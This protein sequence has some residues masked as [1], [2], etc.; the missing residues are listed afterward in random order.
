[1]PAK[2]RAKAS[3]AKTVVIGGGNMGG[4]I[5]RGMV[6]AGV[7]AAAEVV[8]VDVD[9]ARREALRVELEVGVAAEAGAD[10]LAG[11]G[12]VL[13]AVKPQVVEG[14]LAS[15]RSALRGE[16]LVVS[17]VAGV[18]T[19]AVH[20]ALGGACRVVRA[21]PNIAATVG[22]SVTAL[23]GGASAGEEDLRAAEAVFSS[24]GTV[25]RVEERL[26]DA[27]TGV[28]G[29]G[30]AYVFTV[31]EALSDGGVRM[32]LPRGVALELAVQTVLGAATLLRESGEHPAVLR[33]RV[34]T[35]AGTTIAGLYA[36]E[37]GGV[38][39]AILDAVDAATRRSR[40]LGAP[41]AGS[42]R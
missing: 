7:R 29:S 19:R 20:A 22:A 38:R 13:L 16:P 33:D 23:A 39:A 3:T 14:A 24:V 34:T 2:S 31:I 18:E 6:R 37:R 9:S 30:P 10:A 35:P 17:I 36:L 25:V 26:L 21:M 12:M 28:S 5:V 42:E 40:E 41:P 1:M 15:L 8:V 4:A 32:G 27:V 11:A